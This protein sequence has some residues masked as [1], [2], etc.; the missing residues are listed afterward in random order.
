MQARIRAL[1]DNLADEL[2]ANGSPADIVDGSD[3]KC[4]DALSGNGFN[5]ATSFATPISGPSHDW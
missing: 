5:G 4:R 3:R 2:F 1:A